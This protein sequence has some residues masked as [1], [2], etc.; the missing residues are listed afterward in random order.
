RLYGSVDVIDS[1]SLTGD[2]LMVEDSS[3]LYSLSARYEMA[4]GLFLEGGGT[5]IQDGPEIYDIGV[6]FK[7]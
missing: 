2:L 5:K 6:G 4:N 1:L 3:D 7:F